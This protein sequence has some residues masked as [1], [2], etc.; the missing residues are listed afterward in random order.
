MT[1]SGVHDPGEHWGWKL[2]YTT[3]TEVARP[4]K[5]ALAKYTGVDWYSASKA[6]NVIWMY[7]LARRLF[8]SNKTVVAW[9]P[10]FMPGTGLQRQRSGAANFVIKKLMSKVL[11]VLR[12][13]TGKNVRV[14]EESAASLAWLAISEEVEG[15]KGVYYEQKEGK[16]SSVFSRE[17]E[18]QEDLWKWTG[19]FVARDEVERQRFE[20]VE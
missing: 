11:P 5:E 8:S 2:P 20:R 3:A 10:G 9:D 6:A 17:E 18:K 19:E 12:G 15:N 16:V 13:V 14:P 7:A 1:S 4:S